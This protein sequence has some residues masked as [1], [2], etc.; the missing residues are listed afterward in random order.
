MTVDAEVLG[1]VL[2][3]KV[4]E[5]QHES[6]LPSCRAVAVPFILEIW[7]T[8]HHPVIDLGQSQTFFGRTFNSFGDE[9]CI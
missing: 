1:D 6:Y 4:T 5:T 9:V 3:V 7:H 2:Q 8:L